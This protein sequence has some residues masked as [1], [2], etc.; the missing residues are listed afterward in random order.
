M[1]K[2]EFVGQYTIQMAERNTFKGGNIIRRYELFGKGKESTE[3]KQGY[4]WLKL[5]YTEKMEDV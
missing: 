1:I 5:C 2:D 3:Q 4:L